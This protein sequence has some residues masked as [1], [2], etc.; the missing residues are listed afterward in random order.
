[1]LLTSFLHFSHS[2]FTTA[3]DVRDL[4]L[5]SMACI[6]GYRGGKSH[7]V[8]PCQESIRVMVFRVDAAAGAAFRTVIMGCAG[9]RSSHKG[10]VYIPS[11]GVLAKEERQASP[12]G[13][14]GVLCLMFKLFYNRDQSS[15]K[16]PNI[17]DST[18]NH[19]TVGAR[20]ICWLS[21]DGRTPRAVGLILVH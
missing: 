20:D 19:R 6:I 3:L 10:D 15:R 1:M 17:R 2:H 5:G 21:M 12:K 8:H 7:P 13:C 11:P 9:T 14:V 4:Y 16:P 18:F